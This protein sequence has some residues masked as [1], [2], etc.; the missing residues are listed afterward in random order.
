MWQ[1]TAK[2]RCRRNK[3][4]SSFNPRW[5]AAAIIPILIA[6]GL[7]ETRTSVLQARLFSAIAR[8]LT[9]QV[10]PGASSRIVFPESGPFNE[11]R[12]YSKIPRFSR[13]LVDHHFHIAAQSLF[14]TDL[15]RLSRWGITPPYREPTTAGLVISDRAGT[16][17]YDARSRR[18]T[19]NSFDE[20]PPLVASALVFVENRELDEATS[21]THNPVVDWGRSAKA[22]AFYAGKKVGLPLPVEGG[23]TLATQIE[24]YQYSDKGRTQSASDKL[25]QMVSATIRVY[26]DGEDTRPQRREIIL[27][28]LN[29]APLSAAPSYGEVYGIGEGLFAW[30]GKNLDDVRAALNDGTENERT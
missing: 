15:E 10:G 16:I 30:F 26:R 28:Y 17:L 3:R 4:L 11:A 29:S 2:W 14:S 7:Y 25:M 24:K 23:S 22:A 19:F 20:I 6:T 13:E 27:D 9:Y 18:Q 21:D 5:F 1:L 12:G 8:R